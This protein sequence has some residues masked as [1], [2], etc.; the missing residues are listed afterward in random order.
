MITEAQ[1]MARNWY[2][3]NKLSMNELKSER[4]ILILRNLETENKPV[5]FLGV[6]LELFWLDNITQIQKNY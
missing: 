2:S 5:K 3:S 4:I 1:L 6:I